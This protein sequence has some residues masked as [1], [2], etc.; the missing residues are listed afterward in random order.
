MGPA[1]YVGLAVSS[2]DPAVLG[3]GQFDHVKVVQ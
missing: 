1:A 2:H 3:T